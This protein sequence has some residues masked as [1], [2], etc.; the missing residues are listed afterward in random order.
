MQQHGSKFLASRTPPPSP[1]PEYSNTVASNLPVRGMGSKGQNL[2]SSEY[3]H[4]LCQIKGNGTCINMVENILSAYSPTHPP[5][6]P[7]PDPWGEVKIQ[8]FHN[9]VMLHIKFNGIANA[10][11]W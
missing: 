6:P 5:S 9:I 2:T 1:D 10:A 8:P 3:G 11:T 4:V 7:S